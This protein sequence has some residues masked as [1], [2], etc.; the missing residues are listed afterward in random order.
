MKFK[1]SCF[2]LLALLLTS[3]NLQARTGTWD[4][5]RDLPRGASISVESER[6]LHCNFEM[7]TKD[8]LMCSFINPFA[9][10]NPQILTFQ[11]QDV[12]EVRLDSEIYPNPAKG[13]L[14][15]AGVGAAIGAAGVSNSRGGGAIIFGG[16]GALIGAFIARNHSIHRHHTVYKR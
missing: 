4:D 3:S 13:A 14:I 6:P 1:R 16:I 9:S 5:V 2:V 8:K 10:R 15:G 12:K 7:A 11:R